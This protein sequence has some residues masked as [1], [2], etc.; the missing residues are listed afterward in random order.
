MEDGSSII[1]W[2]DNRAG[3][4]DVYVQ[5]IDSLGNGVVTSVEIGDQDIPKS[6][7]LL[8]AFPNPFNPSTD[9]QYQISDV[10]FVTLK[11]FDVLGREVEILINEKQ[12]VGH[13][14]VKWDAHDF[15]SGIYFYS[16]TVTGD[17]GLMFHDVKKLVL[18]K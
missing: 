17:K 14:S 9:I 13:K 3:N 6:P 16:L 18:L 7:K 11:V 4:V 2:S 15:S 12:D 1:G 8:L 5:K 10:S